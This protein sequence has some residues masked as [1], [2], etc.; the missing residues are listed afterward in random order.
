MHG[1]VRFTNLLLLLVLSVLSL[2]SFANAFYIPGYS[3]KSYR[4]GETIPLFWNKLFSDR[5]QLQYAYAELPFVCPPSGRKRLSGLTSGTSLTLNLGEVLR[6]DRI[7]VSDYELVVGEDQEVSYLCSKEVDAK[8]LRWA[9]DLISDNYEAEWIV[10]N[11]PGA[12]SFVTTDKSRKYY[13]AG[14]KLGYVDYDPATLK[15]LYYI[16]NHV[17]LVIRYHRAPGKDGDNG[18][19][20]VVGFEVYPKSIEAGHRNAETGLPLD[21]ENIERGMELS[22]RA[23]ATRVAG[24]ETISDYVDTPQDDL[25]DDLTG[26]GKL[27]IPY[28]YSVYWRED[29]HLE[30]ARRW[31]MYF[32]NEEDNNKIHWLAIVNSLV[33]SGLLTAVVAVIFARTI[34]GDIKLY[35]KESGVEDGKLKLKR[36][37]RSPDRT[38]RRSMEKAGSG[39]LDQIDASEDAD[40][41]S[42]DDEAVEDITGWKLVHGD[43]F[44]PPPFGSILAPIVGSGTQVIFMA[45]GLVLLSCFGVL[46][47][48]FRGGFI[49]VA[50]A[51][52]VLAGA[53]SGYFSARVYK[54]FGGQ[55]WRRN[56]IVTGTLIPGLIFATIFIL[57]FFVWAQASSTAIPFGTLL[58]LASLWLLIQLPLVYVG[59]WYGFVVVGA[60]DHPVKPNAIPR[61]IPR[62]EWYTKSI[63]TVLLA[64]L[65]PFAVI[66]VELL[67]VFKSMWQDKSGY[68]YVFGFLAVVC[69]I[70]VITVVEVSVVATYVQLCSENYHWWWQSFL[71]GG[72]SS[73][74]IFVYCIWFYAFKLHITGFVSSILFFSYSFLACLVYGLLTGTIGFLASYAFVRRIYSAVKVD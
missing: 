59:S 7:T 42:S 36:K 24:N 65:I 32:A 72:A 14:F 4:D 54:T 22:F 12:T 33:I 19:K 37:L 23:N 58:A 17:T 64:G 62:Q 21:M 57:N 67:F 35:N 39:L 41:S 38:P 16:N 73:I 29:E 9:R 26:D 45:A 50:M 56:V 10:D 55:N 25:D 8:A 3:I 15:P 28:T 27:T 63:Q 49:S 53:F 31:D 68:Y 71:V 69:G 40:V 66:F 30:W 70:L 51:L 46:N 13:A 34:R 20:V 1:D 18:R 6:G 2:S 48:S 11:L 47:P 61:Q 74:W 5:T 60:W 52:F 43:V 44:R